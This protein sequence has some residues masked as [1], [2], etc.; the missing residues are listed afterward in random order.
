MYHQ[1]F[2][3][4]LLCFS[5]G[6]ISG[7]CFAQGINLWS[8]AENKQELFN[9]MVLTN[10]GIAIQAAMQLWIHFWFDKLKRD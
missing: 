8:N 2:F 10:I 3:F 5:I 4:L 7:V 9:G 1:A 6:G